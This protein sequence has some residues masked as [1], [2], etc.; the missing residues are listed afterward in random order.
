[1]GLGLNRIKSTRVLALGATATTFLCLPGRWYSVPLYPRL[2]HVV[3]ASFGRSIAKKRAIQFIYRQK[4][5]SI[6]LCRLELGDELEHVV[7]AGVLGEVISRGIV[8]AS[9]VLGHLD[10]LDDAVDDVHAEALAPVGAELTHR[11]GVVEGHAERCG[12]LGVWVSE[13]GDVGSGDLLVHRPRAHHRR[14][15]D[16]VH[17]HFVD[18]GSLEF[19]L[20]REI[21]RDLARGSG[22][23]E[24]AGEADHDGLLAREARGGVHLCREWI[25]G[26]CDQVG[27]AAK[28]A[29]RGRSNGARGDG[30]AILDCSFFGPPGSRVLTGGSGGG[31][32]P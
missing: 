27:V 18:S 7:D 5:F 4:S 12:E 26:R 1:M 23:C 11:S 28:G 20:S 32:A 3:V 22:G 6:R 9:L 30:D 24:G 14:V 8:R 17:E 31:D 10:H 15:I 21:S 25:V 13:E 16:A 2:R 29:R 19:V